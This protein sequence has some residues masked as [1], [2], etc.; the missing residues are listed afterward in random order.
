MSSQMFTTRRLSVNQIIDRFTDYIH[1]LIMSQE[2]LQRNSGS[3]GGTPSSL[4]SNTA[5]QTCV[6]CV[7]ELLQ[8]EKDNCKSSPGSISPQS[9]CIIFTLTLIQQSGS[10]QQCQEM[11]SLKIQKASLHTGHPSDTVGCI[12]GALFVLWALC[13]CLMRKKTHTQ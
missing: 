5:R 4:K 2:L 10:L 13:H 1:K 3:A 12:S 11:S 7:Y 8:H 9:L 6:K